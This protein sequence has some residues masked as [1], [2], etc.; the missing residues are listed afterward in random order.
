MNDSSA[1]P[2]SQKIREEWNQRVE[3]R[4]RVHHR[5]MI[6]CIFIKFPGTI[7]LGNPMPNR[8]MRVEA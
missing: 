3:V 5:L 1:T 6:L 4:G 8:C 7:P 2:L